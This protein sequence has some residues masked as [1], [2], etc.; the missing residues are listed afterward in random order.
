MFKHLTLNEFDMVGVSNAIKRYEDSGLAPDCELRSREE[1]KIWIKIIN[2][3][4]PDTF[5]IFAL[6]KLA[7][8]GWFKDKAH[9]VIQLSSQDENGI[10]TRGCVA[11]STQ[12]TVFSKAEVDLKHGFLS[13]ASFA[14]AAESH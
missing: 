10:R 7:K 8:P 9:W 14:L 5:A 13:I 3:M 11:A 4:M 12:A 2:P 6:H 1:G